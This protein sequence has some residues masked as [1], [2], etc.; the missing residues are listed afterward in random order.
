MIIRLR[1]DTLQNWSTYNPVLSQGEPGFELDTGLLKIGDG[2]QAWLDLPYL[3]LHAALTQTDLDNLKTD[4][5]GTGVP[6]ALDTLNE[7]AAALGDDA[8][9]AATIT[10]ELATKADSAT[11]T[12]GLATKEDSAHKGAANGYMALDANNRGVQAPKLHKADHATGGADAM[13]PADIGAAKAIPNNPAIFGNAFTLPALNA[14]ARNTV[15]SAI[16]ITARVAVVANPQQNGHIY[17]ETSPDQT[18]WITWGYCACR[19]N[20]T[21]G[22]GSG[23]VQSGGPNIGSGCGLTAK[24]PNQWYYRLR[25]LTASGY[26]APFFLYESSAGS[27]V[28]VEN[29]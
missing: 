17:L 28:G 10:N 11:V 12:D 8:N 16:E 19:N 22:T 5:L 26:S 24:V 4:I 2:I 13:T 3:P 6:A 29:S 9:L 21:S 18:N 20:Q 27:Y 25:S 23:T 1:R 15:G 7:L 14:I